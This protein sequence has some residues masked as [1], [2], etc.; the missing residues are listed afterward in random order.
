MD[1]NAFRQKRPNIKRI[2]Q[3]TFGFKSSSFN[4]SNRFLYPSNWY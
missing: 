4:L 3:F 1:F 2:A